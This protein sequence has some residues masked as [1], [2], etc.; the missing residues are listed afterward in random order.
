L[1][2]A[3][4]TNNGGGA[5]P[6]APPARTQ[7]TTA[8]SSQIGSQPGSQAAVDRSRPSSRPAPKPALRARILAAFSPRLAARIALS[9]AAALACFFAAEQIAL[10]W[11]ATSLD[12][13]GAVNLASGQTFYGNIGIDWSGDFVIRSTTD[14]EG[15]PPVTVAV[16]SLRTLTITGEP[17]NGAPWRLITGL[18]LALV[19]AGGAGWTVFRSKRWKT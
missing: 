7:A 17:A 5:R 4:P 18:I 10:R 15:V 9:A 19:A 2:A 13:L 3:P 8:R 12:A 14:D 6:V 16:S 11:E 1:S